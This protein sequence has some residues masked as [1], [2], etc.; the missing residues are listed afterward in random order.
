MKKMTCDCVHCGC[1][2]LL[3]VAWRLGLFHCPSCG[4]HAFGPIRRKRDGEVLSDK[5]VYAKEV[6]HDEF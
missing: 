6:N 3:Y 5:D 4:A 2:G 1:T